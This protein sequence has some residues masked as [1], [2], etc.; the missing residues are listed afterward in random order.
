MRRARLA[1][2]SSE[3]E[4]GNY[5]RSLDLVAPVL[6]VIKQS[7][8]GLFL[9]ATDFLNTGDRQAAAALVE[10][11]TRLA[12]VPQAWSIKFALLLA[13][14]G[15][16]TGAV[17]ILERVKQTS[18]PSYELAFNLGGLHLLGGDPARA[19]EN[20]DVALGLEPNSVPALRQ[21]AA[22]AERQNELERSL[23]Y[24]LRARKLE[25]NDPRSSSASVGSA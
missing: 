14:E 17:D 23:S 1:L 4:R 24:W 10:D 11:W 7:P 6:A 22:T 18:P 2:A 25:P 8:D 12:G 13:K 15:A 19:L 21:A 9:L 3:A 20:Y 16:V 5:Q